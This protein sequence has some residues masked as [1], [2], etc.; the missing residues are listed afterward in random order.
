MSQKEL[1]DLLSKFK[2]LR[3]AGSNE[4]GYLDLICFCLY[5]LI[6][7]QG[8]IELFYSVLP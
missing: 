4:D 6:E 2:E 1:A 7:R 8:P 5:R 3:G